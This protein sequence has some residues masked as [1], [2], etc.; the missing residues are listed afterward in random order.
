MLSNS[1]TLGK[2]FLSERKKAWLNLRIKFENKKKLYIVHGFILI[3]TN[4]S[5]ITEALVLCLNR[6]FFWGGGIIF[7]HGTV[8]H[9]TVRFRVRPSWDFIYVHDDN[10][11]CDHSLLFANTV[12]YI[13][14]KRTATMKQSLFVSL[15]LVMQNPSLQKKF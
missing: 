14:R 13:N 1:T 9:Y 5:I 10:K 15:C 12:K 8:L 4:L 3:V 11:S 6:V 2:K 7:S